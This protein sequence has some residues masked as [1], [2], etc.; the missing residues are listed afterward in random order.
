MEADEDD[1]PRRPTSDTVHDGDLSLA[2]PEVHW[3]FTSLNDRHAIKPTNCAAWQS[4]L[5]GP[6]PHRLRRRFERTLRQAPR[7]LA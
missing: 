5:Y 2:G 4:A 1:V 7:G 3:H 6:C